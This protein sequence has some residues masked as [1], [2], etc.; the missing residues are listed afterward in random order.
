MTEQIKINS[1]ELENVKRIKA[2]KIEPTKNG[3]TVV[4]GKNR[5]GKTS[6][7]DAIAWA[8]GGDRFKP[9]EAHREGSMTPPNLRVVLS[10]GIVVERKGKNSDLKVTDPNGVRSGQKLLDSFIEELA[11]NL[12]KFMES[13]DKQKAETLLKII[14]LENEL[15]TLELAYKKHYQERL[16]T[17]QLRDQKKK[18]ANE[19]TYYPD[20]PNQ[21]ISASDLIQQQQAILARNAE[22]KAKRDKLA[23]YLSQKEMADA[24]L[25]EL[26]QKIKE[27]KEAIFE[28]MRDIDIAQQNA[29]DLQDESTEE[30]EK[31][32]QNVEALNVK[33]RANLDKEKAEQ[34][35]S[36]YDD[37]YNRYTEELKA[38]QKHKMEL[39]QNADLPLKELSVEA[40]LL[41][42]KGQQW[43]NMSGAEQLKVATAIVR[44]LKPQCGFVL[45]DKL[46]QM[47]LETLQEFSEWVANEGLQV[48]AT[49]VSVGE[50]CSVIITDGYSQ[51]E[52]IKEEQIP[53]VAENATVTETVPRY[54][55]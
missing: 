55:W 50:E 16:T 34:E 52:G 36:D 30:L 44:K 2:V 32:I 24:K 39:L 5:Q 45:L 7:L 21:L 19:L 12:P 31:N 20:V 33:I 15:T 18:Y 38:I 47:D 41:T 8:L 17:G 13:S 4:G 43:D 53:T 49:R 3:L 35:A 22:N 1:L 54:D 6:V 37:Q 40:G 42:Y 51:N 14:G 48:I 29:K 28:L 10:N 9:S 46:E 26:E 25:K 11:L 23:Y 27:Q